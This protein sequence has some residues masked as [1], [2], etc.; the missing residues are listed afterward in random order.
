MASLKKE[1]L[2]KDLRDLRE[3][4]R[5]LRGYLALNHPFIGVGM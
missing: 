4:Q 1:L 5:E 2:S 3:A